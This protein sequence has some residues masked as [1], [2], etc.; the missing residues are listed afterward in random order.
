MC[1]RPLHIDLSRRSRY[2]NLGTV[3]HREVDVPCGKCWQCQM[4]QRNDHLLR[5][6]D[7]YEQCVS[8]GGRVAFLT[9]TY[10][11]DCVPCYTYTLAKPDNPAEDKE[12]VITFSPVSRDAILDSGDS[13]RYVFSFNK[14]HFR[15]MLK[16]V[17]QTL[18]RDGY[19][20]SL[21]YIVCS[22]YGTDPRYTQRPHYHALFFLDSD[23]LGI[24][25]SKNTDF[26]NYLS[27]FW[28][29]GKVSASDKG[30]Y[31]ESDKGCAYISKYVTKAQELLK[32]RNFKQL[33]EFIH[34]NYDAGFRFPR[35]RKPLSY[36]YSL[37]RHHGMSYFT[38]KSLYFGKHISD[39]LLDETPNITELLASLDKGVDIVRYGKTEQ[40]PYPR[41]N[42]R[43][44]FY[45]NR[46][47]GSYY[48][49]P[50]GCEVFVNRCVDDYYKSVASVRQWI[51]E[52][53]AFVPFD[54]KNF[55]HKA[56]DLMYRY[57]YPLTFYN[58]FIRGR[59]FPRHVLDSFSHELNQFLY[60]ERVDDSFVVNFAH[61]LQQSEVYDD[62]ELLDNR[63]PTM[64]ETLSYDDICSTY[65][66][67]GTLFNGN[68]EMIIDNYYKCRAYVEYC[69]LKE[70]NQR[71]NDIKYLKDM[72]N[73]QI[74]N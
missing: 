14:L 5:I 32:L 24:L 11:E 48:L 27:K 26:L 17:R 52:Q 36:F 67:Y 64:Q 69:K 34:A 28:H 21:R 30:L 73:Q 57:A 16:V 12:R 19:K 55:D 65:Y 68:W 7:E 1:L 42:L 51:T 4:T 3:L 49:N 43:K 71:N 61:C 62:L 70:Y 46:S 33:L 31:L 66:K 59:M 6:K 9:F 50:L 56:L 29:Y 38:L 40:L 8:K 15:N 13:M 37:L 54:Q 23:V 72:F 39:R 25:E 10:R 18:V 47:D 45:G 53:S 58:R 20:G 60:T 63:Y 44:L 35:D 74:Y 22:E 2:Y 41:Y